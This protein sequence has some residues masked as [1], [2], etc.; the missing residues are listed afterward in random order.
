MTRF[1]L[2]NCL[3]KMPGLRN[4]K[5]AALLRDLLTASMLSPLAGHR[6]RY[7]Q[8]G[9]RS[10]ISKAHNLQHTRRSY[11]ILV[12]NGAATSTCRREVSAVLLLFA[13]ALSQNTN[14]LVSACVVL[15]QHVLTRCAIPALCTGMW[16][17]VLLAVRSET[18]RR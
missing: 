4:C 11:F 2:E 7:A 6:Q 1:W 3:L 13:D 12:T 8:V 17:S 14:F 15:D 18:R 5:A 10:R 9:Q 16:Y